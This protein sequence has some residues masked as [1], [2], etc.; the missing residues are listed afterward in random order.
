V[1][2]VTGFF[3][4]ICMM[5]KNAS[6]IAVPKYLREKIAQGEHQQLD[7]KY[8]IND[9]RKIA[10]T[11]CAFANTDGGTLLIGVKDNGSIAGAKLQEETYMIES[12]AKM[13]CQPP[14]DFHTQGWKAGDRYVLEV[15]I[16]PSIFKPHCAE[17]VDGK[18]IAYLRSGDQNFPAPAVMMHYWRLEDTQRGERYQHTEKEQRIFEMLQNEHGVTASDC[19]RKL[20]IPRQEVTRLLAKFLRWDLIDMHFEQGIARYKALTHS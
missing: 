12:A 14:I 20:N 3:Y 8:A 18:W 19:A 16:E 2:F 11:L 4:F 1:D 6:P 17:D 9:A 10:I 5:S 13:Y 7:F 15:I